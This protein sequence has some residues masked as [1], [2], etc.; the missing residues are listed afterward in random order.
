MILP[1]TNQKT[2]DLNSRPARRGDG[3]HAEIMGWKLATRDTE[4]MARYFP[5]VVL[6][7][8]EE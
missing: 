5:R 7:T 1:D 4:R 2:G 6:L 8:P 3:S